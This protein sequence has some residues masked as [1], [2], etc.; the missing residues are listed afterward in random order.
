MTNH[1]MHTAPVKGPLPKSSMVPNYSF[2]LEANQLAFARWL[3]GVNTLSQGIAQF[4]QNRLREDMT[5]RSTLASCNSPEDAFECQRRFAQEATAGYAAEVAKLSQTMVSLARRIGVAP[6]RRRRGL[7]V[8][9]SPS[10][11][12]PMPSLAM[13]MGVIGA[14]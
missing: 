7:Q 4:T 8:A 9:R 13:R 14:I 2:L 10:L 6:T 12:G 1:A 3:N 11:R 5:A